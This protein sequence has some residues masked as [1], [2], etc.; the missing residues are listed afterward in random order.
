MSPYARISL[1]ASAR[2]SYCKGALSVVH[3]IAI[4]V[5]VILVVFVGAYAM[6][7]GKGTEAQMISAEVQAV[8][9]AMQRARLDAN[10]YP[11][12]L[13]VLV[14]ASRG[15]ESS[16]GTDISK[17]LRGPYLKRTQFDETGAIVLTA[18][19][20]S[21]LQIVGTEAGGRP[22][23]RLVGVQFDVAMSVLDNAKEHGHA[24]RFVGYTGNRALVDIFWSL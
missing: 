14:D 7:D 6:T 23:L 11:T 5:A 10:C 22:E 9:T 20:A 4:C 15:T 18:G 12:R 2:A 19:N 3:V 24:V 8:R 13:D 21:R 17:R 1:R 16:C